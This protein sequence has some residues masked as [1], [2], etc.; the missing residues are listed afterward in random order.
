MQLNAANGATVEVSD[1]VF[2]VEYNEAWCT[3]W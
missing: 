2:G 1:S 3:R